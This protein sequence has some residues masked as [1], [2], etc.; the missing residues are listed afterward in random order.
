MSMISAP[1]KAVIMFHADGQNET[2][3][4][5]GWEICDGRLLNSSQ[6]D[7]NPGGTYQLPDL[8][9]IIIIGADITE[10][11]Q[12]SGDPTKTDHTGAPGPKGFGGNN[13]V[14]LA[15]TQVPGYSLGSLVLN[16]TSGSVITGYEP[17]Q[18]PGGTPTTG[19]FVSTVGLSG[20]L[21]T[22]SASTY[23]DKRPRFYGLV[24]IMKVR[25]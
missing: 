16:Q 18:S 13:S 25:I 1:L 21:G 7:I 6:Q 5:E 8:R 14:T 20:S 11:T 9:N 3:T 24:Y 19:T 22:S 2:I 10:S 4:A 15:S 17:G 12:Y 23:V